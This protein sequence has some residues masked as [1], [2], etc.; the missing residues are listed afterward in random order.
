MRLIGRCIA[1]EKVL[2]LIKRFLKAGYMED[3]KYHKTYSGTPQGGVL[4]PLLANIFL[5]Q[6]DNFMMKELEANKTQTK[7]ESNSRRNPEYRVLENKITKLRRKLREGNGDRETVN[8]IKE[9]ERQRK[10]IPHYA[11]EIKHPGKIW[12]T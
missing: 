12:Y 7:R 9:L 11:K 4:S 6:L 2:N 5:H 8:E 3:W 10:H 1:D